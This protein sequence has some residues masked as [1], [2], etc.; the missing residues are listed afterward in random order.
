LKKI[1]KEA[2]HLDTAGGSNF[3]LAE[4]FLGVKMQENCTIIRIKKPQ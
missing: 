3:F 2:P 1:E 4:A